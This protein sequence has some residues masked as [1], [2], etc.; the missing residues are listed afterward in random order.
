MASPQMTEFAPAEFLTG[1]S[2]ALDTVD[3][4][5]AAQAVIHVVG[6]AI[7]SLSAEVYAHGHAPAF[8]ATPLMHLLN[9]DRGYFVATAERS[10]DREQSRRLLALMEEN[11]A[12]ELEQ[13]RELLKSTPHHGGHE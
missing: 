13:F 6:A 5:A 11:L 1:L 8:F 4:A 10:L 9:L 12:A 2:A 3:D 7:R